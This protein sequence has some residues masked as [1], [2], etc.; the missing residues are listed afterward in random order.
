MVPRYQGQHKIKPIEFSYFDV[1]SKQYKTI[2]TKEI[3]VE[4]E[5][6][7]DKFI[8]LTSGHSKEDVKYI[9]QD[10][11]F[12][13][14]GSAKFERVGKYFHKSFLFF[15][16]LILP[17]I[18]L[19]SA[20]GYRRHLDKLSGNI[21]YA[22]SRKANQMAMKRLAKARKYL[23]EA[24]QKEFYAEVSNSMMGF[25]GDKLNI[26]SAGI[27]TDEVEGLMKNKGVPEE[28]VQQYLLCLKLCDYQR[29]APS[30]AKIEEMKLFFDEAK[31]AIV[32]LEKVI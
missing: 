21:A 14:L 9:G 23:I 12:I 30:N 27:I 24:T 16:I 25:L 11:R 7:D 10:I 22:R 6:S 1:T 4:V 2:R 5:K 28:V 20:Y 29:F 3:L 31:Q 8:A 13:Q 26:A 32:S 19:G 17:L 15:V 18:A